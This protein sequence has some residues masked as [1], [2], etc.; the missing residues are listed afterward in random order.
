L[1]IG[2]GIAALLGVLVYL[3]YRRSQL[4]RAEKLRSIKR[5][6]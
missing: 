5:A 2:I 1:F 6:L 3:L 4:M